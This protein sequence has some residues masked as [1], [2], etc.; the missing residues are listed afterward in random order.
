MLSSRHSSQSILLLEPRC[1]SLLKYKHR[2]LQP[3]NDSDAGLSS[4]NRSVFTRQQERIIRPSSSIFGVQSEAMQW[5]KGR[6]E[7]HSAASHETATELQ[8]H[9]LLY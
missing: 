5:S 3:S 6:I 8:G 9:G 4:S 7:M 1:R 2:N